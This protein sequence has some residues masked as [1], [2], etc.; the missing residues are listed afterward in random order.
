[1]LPTLQ[2]LIRGLDERGIRYCHWKSNWALH[3]TLAG[4]TDVD[5]LVQRTHAPA[6]RGLLHELEF[7]PAIEARVD[8]VPSLEHYHALDP[9]GYLVH[10][11]AYYRTVSGGSL[12]KEFHFP[13]EE[14]LLGN[15]RLV[16]GIRVPSRAAELVV[17]ALRMA[18]KHTSVAELA[19]VQ[20]DWDAVA[21]E[22]K[23]LGADE[24]CED[25][26]QL[27]RTWL[28]GFDP[29]V[30]RVAVT[31]ICTSAPLHR[32]VA[33][34]HRVRA[35]LRSYA[36]HGRITTT[37][38][39]T[40]K[41]GERSLRRL[42]SSRKGLTPSGGGAVIAFVGPEASG[43]STLLDET[44]S[45]LAEHFTVTRVH[46]GKP[47]STG[48][49]VLPNA[50]L[51]LLRRLL[52]TQRSTRVSLGTPVDQEAEGRDVPVL[53]AMRSVL[54]AHDRRALLRQAFARAANGEIVLCDRYPSEEP[55]SLDGAQL[56][57]RVSP[58]GGSER[59]AH[60]ARLED[61]LYRN[62]PPPDLVVRLNAPL[63]LTLERN[64][65]RT[66]TEGESYVKGRYEASMRMEFPRTPV[67]EIATTR[68]LEECLAEL[69]QQIWAFL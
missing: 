1:M 41:L 17:F 43:K 69:K 52:P 61:A 30:F 62:I 49:S 5:L 34:G 47:P 67:I 27:L 46:A 58:R 13:V 12:T 6:F 48:L 45:W 23:W 50:L 28:P 53:Y 24:G 51:P 9:G 65:A 10:V 42:S 57:G 29:S 59:L 22:A 25:A 68:P 15:T 3:H 36:R 39:G 7:R 32:R 64:R 35:E 2:S 20:R 8:P 56:A 26:V 18:V 66:K 37:L 44:A 19:L 31:A 60:L 54:L 11:H 16:E 21:A 4:K 63:E 38:T 55:G 33:V 14:M 40:G